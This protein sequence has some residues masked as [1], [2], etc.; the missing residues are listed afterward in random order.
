MATPVRVTLRY[1]QILDRKDLDEYGEFV[2]EFRVSAPARGLNQ[3]TRIPD[4]GHMSLS[5]H[6]AMNKVTLD[7]VIFEGQ[8]EDGDTLVIEATGEELD[9][10]SSNDQVTEYRREFTGPVSGWIG[11]YT[12][13]DEGSDEQRDAEQLGDWRLSYGIERA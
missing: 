4:S 3:V 8:V 12:P 6:A 10:L 1:I 5:D 2:F 9:Q 7:R 11:E 13:W